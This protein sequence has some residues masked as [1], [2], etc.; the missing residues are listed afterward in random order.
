[1]K[2]FAWKRF[3]IPREATLNLDGGGYLPDPEGESTRQYNP[4]VVPFESIEA[5]PCLGLLGEPGMGKTY[6]L[7]S[8]RKGIDAKISGEGGKS[9]WVDLH[10]YG[11]EGR[12]VKD[13][14][15]CDRFKEW[16]DGSHV[17][18]LF[19]DSLDECRMRI[20]TLSAV[21]LS[22]LRAAPCDRL[23]LRIA[24]RTDDWPES[25]ERGL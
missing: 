7:Q 21:L 24:C 23:R 14:F 19:L 1:M 15:E 12:L 5:L 2:V 17:L 4:D 6:A 20:T 25:L 3:W 22:K 13:I 11:D 16:A 9:L 18:H 10:E 8:L